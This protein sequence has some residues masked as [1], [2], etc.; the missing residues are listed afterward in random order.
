MPQNPRQNERIS[1][2][3]TVVLDSTSGKREARISDVSMGGCFIDSI[4]TVREGETLSFNLS[5][6]TGL[7]DK[8]YGE[9]V[10]VYPGIGFGLR[11]TGLTVAQ[12]MLIKQIILEKS[13]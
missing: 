10:Y 6:S 12:R 3:L 11:F 4:A 1:I 9:I 5:L 8:L 2:S 13:G 7:S